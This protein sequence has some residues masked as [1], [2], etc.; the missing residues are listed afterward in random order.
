[1]LDLQ[2]AVADLGYRFYGF[3]SFCL[4]SPNL[5]L[6]IPIGQQVGDVVGDCQGIAIGIAMRVIF[7]E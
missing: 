3:S 6:I 1:M 7:E 4:V 2:T 5:L